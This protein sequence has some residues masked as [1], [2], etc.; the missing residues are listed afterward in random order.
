V[1]GGR[2]GDDV[3]GGRGGDGGCGGTG[4]QGGKGGDGAN[5]VDGVDGRD[6]TKHSI[7]GENASRPT[8]G[9]PAKDGGRGGDGGHGGDAGHGAP[10][11]AVVIEARESETHLLAMCT[12]NAAGGAGGVRGEG[13][14]GGRGGPGGMG[15]TGGAGA[16]GG[17]PCRLTTHHGDG[18]TTV[19]T[20]RRGKSYPAAPDG[21]DGLDGD[22]GE[23][24][25]SGLHGRDAPGG[26]VLF[27]VLPDSASADPTQD[28]EPVQPLLVSNTMYHP[29]VLSCSLMDAEKDG[30]VEPNSDVFVGDIEVKN[31]GGLPTPLKH[32]SINLDTVARGAVAGPDEED[33]TVRDGGYQLPQL[34][35]QD[36][37]LINPIDVHT[38]YADLAKHPELEKLTIHTKDAPETNL[39]LS[40]ATY[41][42]LLAT[43]RSVHDMGVTAYV[44]PYQTAVYLQ[45]R[46]REMYRSRMDLDYDARWPLKLTRLD[47]TSVK[48]GM[49]TLFDIS[50]DVE[51]V[52]RVPLEGDESASGSDDLNNYVDLVL[53]W[54][55]SAV[56]VGN[57]ET[58]VVPVGVPNSEG[59]VNIQQHL[60]PRQSGTDKYSP[61]SIP[62]RVAGAPA[63]PLAHGYRVYLPKVDALST[64]RLSL[65]L[66]VDCAI[67]PYLDIPVQARMYYHGRCIQTYGALIIVAPQYTHTQ[68]GL[69]VAD[70]TMSRRTYLGL[71]HS[72][73]EMNQ[74]CDVFDAELY[75]GISWNK[76]LRQQGMPEDSDEV[77]E[78]GWAGQYREGLTVLMAEGQDSVV[79]DG[80][81]PVASLAPVDP[82]LNFAKRTHTLSD[83]LAPS[84][85]LSHFYPSSVEGGMPPAL[86][87]GTKYPPKGVEAEGARADSALLVVAPSVGHAQAD[88]HGFVRR[89]HENMG[90]LTG[91]SRF[92]GGMM[93]RE[94][95]MES[96]L[97]DKAGSV[98]DS[99]IETETPPTKTMRPYPAA[100]AMPSPMAMEE[101]LAAPVAPGEAVAVGEVTAFSMTLGCMAGGCSKYSQMDREARLKMARD[102][103]T[104]ELA[105]RDKKTPGFYHTAVIDGSSVLEGEVGCK[106]LPL[107]NAAIYRQAV[108]TLSRV[109]AC[110]RSTLDD[111]DKTRLTMLRVLPTHQS[112]QAVCSLLVANAAANQPRLTF[113]TVPS[114][115]E[116]DEV[117]MSVEDVFGAV[118]LADMQDELR[119][120]VKTGPAD[121]AKELH[122][123]YQSDMA[124]YN[125][126]SLAEGDVDAPEE[127]E[128]EGEADSEEDKKSSKTPVP[129]SY[130]SIG[131]ADGVSWCPVK[132][133]QVLSAMEV[134]TIAASLPSL[135]VP[136]VGALVTAKKACSGKA[137]LYKGCIDDCLSLLHTLYRSAPQDEE[138]PSCEWLYESGVREKPVVKGGFCSPAVQ[139]QSATGEVVQGTWQTVLKEG[140]RRMDPRYTPAYSDLNPELVHLLQQVSA[141][142]LVVFR[143]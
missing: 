58:K 120:V 27:R 50:M 13:G 75:K 38:T 103:I 80:R 135:L 85:F 82:P 140:K 62:A 29:A 97:I 31:C 25:N 11:G 24:G 76:P 96:R 56:T 3:H 143:E 22:P 51:N 90:T 37:T 16:Q 138:R 119:V 71:T 129:P 53:P 84:H 87:C 23:H 1:Y 7:N 130:P 131:H 61:D 60:I 2:G 18:R 101:A 110:A 77:E 118:L 83:D 4:G 128:G 126:A 136:M 134:A 122:A 123:Q 17:A 105:R 107:G 8:P 19:K 65:T 112:L 9:H 21:A 95:D 41:Q 132:L 52:S 121:G 47:H 33:V 78:A 94:C 127:H 100:P 70:S 45:A 73:Q 108:P 113:T 106:A 124:A 66:S 5:G 10:G 64:E 111:R 93:S 92:P 88:F 98:V 34:A 26:T 15:G 57:S 102:H 137:K 99:A 67:D 36:T 14:A 39:V 43:R 46:G 6:G 12:Y 79:Q 86:E 74:P 48:L 55:V 125:E 49:G 30:V 139:G 91:V 35:P 89:H 40:Y 133:I 42:D 68:R 28:K 142:D 32:C 104:N 109:Y 81:V 59:A 63:V 115:C 117:E 114:V 20:G 72:L 69:V 54:N 116:G 141:A 44:K